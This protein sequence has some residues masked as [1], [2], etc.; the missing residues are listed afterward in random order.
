MTDIVIASA[1]RTPV[2]SFNG[3]FTNTPAHDL[4]AVA[5]K[6][7]LQ[8]AKVEPGE[9]DEKCSPLGRVR[10]QLVRLR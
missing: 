5:I 8:R 7:A 10:T 9:V 6:A 1:A 3:A 4:G 2:G